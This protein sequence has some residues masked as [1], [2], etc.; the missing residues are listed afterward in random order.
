VSRTYVLAPPASADLD[1]VHAIF[2]D[3]ATWLHLPKGRF[4]SVAETAAMIA[5]LEQEWRQAGLSQWVV[6]AAARWDDVA[7]GDVIGVGGVSPRADGWWNLGYRLAPRAW[8][9]GLA[10]QISLEA[11]E[12]GRRLRPSWPVVARLLS[13]NPGSERVSRRAGLHEVWRGTSVHDADLDR[14]VL[15]DRDLDPALLGS[16][17]ALG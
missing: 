8:G 13:N 10:V 15:A 4:S 17:V 11:I 6:R 5:D 3:P 16:I 14:L 9:R 7:L 2:S 1:E 12:M